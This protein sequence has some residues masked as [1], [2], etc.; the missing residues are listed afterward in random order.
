ML[1]AIKRFFGIGRWKYNAA[2]DQRTC[3]YTGVVQVL[4]LDD[5]GYYWQ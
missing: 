4:A 2:Y 5:Q 1:Q 3:K